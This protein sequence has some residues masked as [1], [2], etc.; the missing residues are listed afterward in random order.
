M[1]K[2]GKFGEI[3]DSSFHVAKMIRRSSALR[4]DIAT[5]TG[6]Q[7]IA[8]WLHNSHQVV[9]AIGCIRAA[10]QDRGMDQMLRP[11]AEIPKDEVHGEASDNSLG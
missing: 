10:A 7:A 2:V 8:V 6:K 3:S 4:K 5:S 11:V 1:V 9:L